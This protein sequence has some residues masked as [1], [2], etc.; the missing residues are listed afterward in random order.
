[1]KKSVIAYGLLVLVGSLGMHRFYLS[2]PRSG[3]V[4]LG[5]TVAVVMFLPELV[6]YKRLSVPTIGWCLVDAFLI[7]GMVRD[8]NSRQSG[9]NS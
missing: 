9:R 1:M 8:C 3:F 5:L 7:P 4:M 6:I 2:R